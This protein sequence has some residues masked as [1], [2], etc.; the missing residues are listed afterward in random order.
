MSLDWGDGGAGSQA[1]NNDG[2]LSALNLCDF[3]RPG[4]HLLTPKFTKHTV[5]LIL[6]KNTVY[7]ITHILKSLHS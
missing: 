5:V 4:L 3:S 6:L 1:S 2:G 7:D